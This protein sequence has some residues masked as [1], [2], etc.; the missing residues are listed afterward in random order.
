MS[1]FLTFFFSMFL[2]GASPDVAGSGSGKDV[3]GSGSGQDVI[4]SGTG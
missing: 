2:S 3:A 4:G 1:A